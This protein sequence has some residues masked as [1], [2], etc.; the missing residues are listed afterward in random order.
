MNLANGVDVETINFA[1]FLLELPKPARLIKVD[2]KGAEW[3]VLPSVTDR[4]LHQ[5]EAMFVETHERF[6]RAILPEAKRLQRLA[7][8]LKAPYINLF[9][10]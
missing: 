2:I 3:A 8:S 1:D 4:A 9:W 10:A 6:D 5:F 7:A